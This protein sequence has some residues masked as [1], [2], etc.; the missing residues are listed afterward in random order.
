MTAAA[1]VNQRVVQG[2]TAQVRRSLRRLRELARLPEEEFLSGPD[3]YAIAEHHLRRCL[4][5][6]LDMG[7]HLIARCG[8]GAAQEYA[9][10]PRLLAEAG[11][12]TSDTANDAAAL[13]K[14]RN[15]LVHFYWQVDAEEMHQVL[16]ERLSTVE[17]FC[18]EVLDWLAEQAA[19]NGV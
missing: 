19:E 13:A 18:R 8:L 10:V 4:E 6:M 17:S 2:Q 14:L 12:L 7:R 1:N 16:S 15:R 3:N 5:A 9:D 11:A